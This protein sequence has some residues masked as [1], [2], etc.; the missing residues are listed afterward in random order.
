MKVERF[1]LEL[2]AFLTWSILKRNSQISLFQILVYIYF[3]SPDADLKH[4]HQSSGRRLIYIAS[5]NLKYESDE[6][7]LLRRLT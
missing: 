2:H 7:V 3:F 5:E 1:L 6:H 4:S